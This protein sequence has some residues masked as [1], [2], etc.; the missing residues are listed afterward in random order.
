MPL[1]LDIPGLSFQSLWFFPPPAKQL[2]VRKPNP[3][4][5]IFR[6]FLPQSPTHMLLL[7][8]LQTVSVPEEQSVSAPPPVLEF[9]FLQILPAVF[10]LFPSLSA[11]VSHKPGQ[12]LFPN[13]FHRY[14][15]K[16]PLF[17]HLLLSVL[18]PKTKPKMSYRKAHN[19]KETGVLHQNS[20]N[21]DSPH[22][23]LPD[24]LP[25]LSFRSGR[26]SFLRKDNPYTAL[27]M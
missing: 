7:H 26:Q 19:Q 14:F 4:Q 17:P 13:I 27:P 5:S 6:T 20:Q 10:P 25:I 15:H 11:A 18:F 23:F 2:S 9:P 3:A 8:S 12:P 22:K 1:F 16:K 24:I 21:I